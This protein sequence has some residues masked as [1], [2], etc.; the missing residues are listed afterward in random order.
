MMTGWYLLKVLEMLGL[1]GLRLY[2]IQGATIWWHRMDG[3]EIRNQKYLGLLI[4]L[5]FHSSP[6]HVPLNVLVGGC[7]SS[8][9][10]GVLGSD[11]HWS[12]MLHTSSLEFSSRWGMV[13]AMH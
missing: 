10:G 11:G 8:P 1:T 4:L 6:R 3:S 12:R 7:M 2:L 5:Y 9:A 13:R